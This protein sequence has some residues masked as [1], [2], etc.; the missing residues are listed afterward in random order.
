MNTESTATWILHVEYGCSE[1]CHSLF[2]LFVVGCLCLLNV[3]RNGFPRP[4]DKSKHKR[5]KSVEFC[6]RAGDP[7]ERFQCNTNYVRAMQ[8]VFV[9]FFSSFL[10]NSILIWYWICAKWPSHSL[11][12]AALFL[13]VFL[14]QWI[15]TVLFLFQFIFCWYFI[16]LCVSHHAIL[17]SCHA[18]IYCCNS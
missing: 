1:R 7:R 12:L 18:M 17:G 15:I 5:I 4:N 6:R 14:G 8:I 3:T 9:L 10:Y 2:C 13:P 11:P 16:P